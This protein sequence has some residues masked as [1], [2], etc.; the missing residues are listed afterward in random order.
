[1]DWS[2]AHAVN[3]FFARHDGLED[4]LLWYVQAAEALF[5]GMLVV[6]CLCARHERWA[7]ARRAAVAAGLSA[8]L[9]LLLAKLITEVYA[10]PRPFVAHPGAVHLFAA[11]ARDPSF[12]S[13]HATASFAIA[14]A[15]LLRSKW[16]WGAATLLFAVVL[17]FGRVAAGFHYPSDVLAGAALGT[18]AA[19]TLWTT[20]ARNVIDALA[21]KIGG[22][23]DRG[24]D[25]VLRA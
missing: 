7:S 10:R 1:M 4:P 17:V 23:F 14:V 15:I 22:T 21:D 20:P 12:P 24:V 25:A 9:G 6:V 3:A 13:D 8:G 18:L 5:F 19:V 16:P 2:I 11:H